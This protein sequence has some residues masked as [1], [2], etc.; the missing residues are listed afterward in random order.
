MA[1]AARRGLFADPAPIEPRQ[2]RR[3]HGP[4]D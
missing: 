4:C 2:F 1:R 3:V